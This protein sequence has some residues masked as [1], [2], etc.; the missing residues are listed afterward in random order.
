VDEIDMVIDRGAFL[1]GRRA[2]VSEDITQIKAE[3]GDK[4]LKVILETAELG[5]YD[6]IASAAL[7]AM[8]AGADFIKTSTGKV[9]GA[10]PGS[11]LCLMEATRD[12]YSETG[13]R[14]GVKVAGGVK[15]SKQALHYLV[16][17]KETLGIEW[18]N[19]DCFRIGA[20]SLLNDILMQLEKER[21]GVYQSNIYFSLDN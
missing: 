5:S 3:C 10:T 15:T 8:E 12:Y 16:M 11:A 6:A 9:G 7:L 21:T 14:V 20:S 13:R 18:V 4:V 17:A 19:P 1:A 2:E